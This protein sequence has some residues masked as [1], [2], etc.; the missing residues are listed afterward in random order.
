MQTNQQPRYI[1]N[2]K[3]YYISCFRK[4]FYFSKYVTNRSPKKHLFN[5]ALYCHYD[6]SNYVETTLISM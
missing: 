4:K 3:S 6:L 2:P 5:I 1:P